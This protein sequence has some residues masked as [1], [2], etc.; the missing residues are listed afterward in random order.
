M[1]DKEKENLKRL[2]ESEQ[3][4]GAMRDCI[5]G[6]REAY[7]PAAMQIRGY[8]ESLRNV[9]FSENAAMFLTLNMI[10]KSIDVGLG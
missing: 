6:Y 7:M 10:N 4:E 5:R 1:T 8:Y 9:G 3:A 2:M